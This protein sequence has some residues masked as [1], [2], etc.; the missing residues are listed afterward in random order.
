[1][2]LF[3]IS[4]GFSIIIIPWALIRFYSFELS[5]FFL[6]SFWL[7]YALEYTVSVRSHFSADI[8]KETTNLRKLLHEECIYMLNLIVEVNIVTYL[9]IWSAF[10]FN[11]SRVY[12][13]R[14]FFRFA[15]ANFSRKIDVCSRDLNF[16]SF[17][18]LCKR[19]NTTHT[20]K[21]PIGFTSMVLL[22][23]LLFIIMCW[24]PML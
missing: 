9:S 15:F 12:M 6:L 20:R 10:I 7:N 11:Y 22:F 14:S 21:F 17:S 24:M 1:M 2:L 8:D 18:N 13:N 19:N 23:F 3:Y 4:L 16:E 5:F